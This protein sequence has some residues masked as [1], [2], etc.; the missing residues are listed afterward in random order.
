MKYLDKYHPKLEYMACGVPKEL[1]KNDTRW[2]G[3]LLI[4]FNNH[5]YYI[6]T[7]MISQPVQNKNRFSKLSNIEIYKNT[8]TYQKVYF[9]RIINDSKY[10]PALDVHNKDRQVVLKATSDLITEI[11][12]ALEAIIKEDLP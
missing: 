10:K 11:Y 7:E 3:S 4:T 6:H 8:N 12:S 5:D 9:Q 1:D 2:G